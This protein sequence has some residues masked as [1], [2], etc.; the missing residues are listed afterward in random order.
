M[1]PADLGVNA[2]KLGFDGRGEG[3]GRRSVVIDISSENLLARGEITAHQGGE[4]GE[5][6]RFAIT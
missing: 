6:D 1:P 3:V 4:D 2:H 5:A